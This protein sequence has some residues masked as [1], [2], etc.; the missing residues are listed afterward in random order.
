[1]TSILQL[2]GLFGAYISVVWQF[3]WQGAYAKYP[4]T[5]LVIPSATL[6]HF[7]VGVRLHAVLVC[8]LLPLLL[9]RWPVLLPALMFLASA[10]AVVVA[11]A[12]VDFVWLPVAI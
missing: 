2:L 4:P 3:L 7:K 11:I 5:V 10:A 6:Q 8:L 12:G 1:V 9:L